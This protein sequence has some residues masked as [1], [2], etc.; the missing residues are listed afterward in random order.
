MPGDIK[1][2]KYY[3]LCSS[4]GNNFQYTSIINLPVETILN[5]FFLKEVK[6]SLL[7]WNVKV[8]FT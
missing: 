2:W 3:L 4:S 6:Y 7:L 5:K 1:A 8:T